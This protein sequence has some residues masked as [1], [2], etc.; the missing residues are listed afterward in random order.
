[1]PNWCSNV[2]L[3][4]GP[5]SS[6]EA[7]REQVAGSESPLDF[8]KIV[9]E[10]ARAADNGDN[11]DW[12]WWRIENWGT[13]WNVNYE[14]HVQIFDDSDPCRLGYMFDTAWAPPIPV[15]RAMADKYRDLKF[16]LLYYEPGEDYAGKMCFEWK[17]GDLMY[18]GYDS[19]VELMRDEL[20]NYFDMSWLDEMDWD[21]DGK[22]EM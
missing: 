15:I 14:G 7:F 6:L 17:N 8:N 4:T 12:Y 22:E 5:A 9:P 11:M 13:K 18:Q 19:T 1:M 3:V 21:D 2:L 20:S 16:Q 10:P